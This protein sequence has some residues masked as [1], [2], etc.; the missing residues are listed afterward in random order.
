MHETD[1]VMVGGTTQEVDDPV[2]LVAPLAADAVDEQSTRGAQIGGSHDEMAEPAWGA[3]DAEHRG[4]ALIGPH[5]R[6]RGIRRDETYGRCGRRFG[7]GDPPRD[8]TPG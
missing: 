1:V 2:D 6:T 5:D 3:R 4:S 7:F 8:R